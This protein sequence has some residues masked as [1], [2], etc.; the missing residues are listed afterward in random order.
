MENDKDK[1]SMLFQALADEHAL[2]CFA[3]PTTSSDYRVPKA[4]LCT[5]NIEG[6]LK[7]ASHLDS[8]L[9]HPRRR[10]NRRPAAAVAGPSEPVQNTNPPP[11][12]AGAAILHVNVVEPAVAAADRNALHAAPVDYGCPE[13]HLLVSTEYYVASGKTSAYSEVSVLRHH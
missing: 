3:L 2:L 12:S 10:P 4:L 1:D 6:R 9:P 5:D 7:A 11:Y 8:L 13:L